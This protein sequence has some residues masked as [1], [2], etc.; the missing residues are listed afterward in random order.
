MYLAGIALELVIA[1]IAMLGRAVTAVTAGIS[2]YLA[3]NFAIAILT[4]VTP[5]R[6]GLVQGINMIAPEQHFIIDDKRRQNCPAC[7]DAA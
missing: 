3:A 6:P 4:G 1:A 5:V 7:G 2:G